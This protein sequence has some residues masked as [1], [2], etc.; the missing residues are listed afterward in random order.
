MLALG[1]EDV[2]VDDP[3]PLAEVPGRATKLMRQSVD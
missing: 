1:A 3:V 2:M